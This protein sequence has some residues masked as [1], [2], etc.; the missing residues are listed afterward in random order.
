[1]KV[2]RYPFARISWDDV[3]PL[4]GDSFFGSPGFANLWRTLGG[5][6]VYWLVEQGDRILAVLPGVEFGIGP[7]KR[8]YA[9]PAGCYGRLFYRSTDS[10]DSDEIADFFVTALLNAGYMKWFIYDYY[11]CFRP[12]VRLEV[13]PCQTRI[14][15]ISALDWK[16]PDKRLQAEIRKAYRE[17]TQMETF[18]PNEQFS[19][20]LTLMEHTERRYGRHPTYPSAFFMELARLAR[21]DPRVHWKWCEHDGRP[22]ASHIDFV[23]DNMVI[24]WQTYHDK[25]FSYLKANQHMLFAT[26]REL[27]QTGVKY[28]NLSASPDNAP[29]VEYYKGKWGGEQYHYNCYSHKSILGKL[30]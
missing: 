25:S 26:A 29:N 10:D 16:P 4:I 2:V 17:G 30:V 18:N 5:R 3:A 28:L 15:D 21:Y 8:F 22:V 27:A 11:G 24:N 23:D 20:F 14:V 19:K 6:P 9:M 7:F 12:S 1:M 13:L